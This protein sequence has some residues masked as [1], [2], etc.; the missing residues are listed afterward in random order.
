MFRK[1]D[2]MNFCSYSLTPIGWFR[3]RAKYMLWIVIGTLMMALGFVVRIPMH[4]NATS[5]P[6]YTVQTLLRDLSEQDEILTE[7]AAHPPFTLRVHRTGLP[8][9][10]TP[11]GIRRCSRL[12]T[13]S[14]STHWPDLHY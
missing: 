11:C 9:S 8:R 2:A 10:T 12:S 4:S 5:I 7:F 6:I 13:A 3:S 1:T 14:S